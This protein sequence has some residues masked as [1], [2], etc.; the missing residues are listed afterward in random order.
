MYAESQIL[1]YSEQLSNNLLDELFSF[2]FTLHPVQQSHC[3]AN[4]IFSL[5]SQWPLEFCLFVC[6]FVC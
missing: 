2:Q 6:L 1:P 5:W 3:G 4:K